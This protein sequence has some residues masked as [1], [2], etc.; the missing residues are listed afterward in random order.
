MVDAPGHAESQAE[1]LAE[2]VGV[3]A[4]EEEEEAEAEADGLAAVAP[5][6]RRGKARPR[7]P[8]RWS[9]PHREAL[10]DLLLLHACYVGEVE[11]AEL[12]ARLART[13]KN[14][15][16]ELIR[17]RRRL[18]P[19]IRGRWTAPSA[20]ALMAS[21]TSPKPARL[22]P[23]LASLDQQQQQ[24]VAESSQPAVRILSL[25]T[26]DEGYLGDEGPM[27][28]VSMRMSDTV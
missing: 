4:E 12:A 17:V 1:V 6:R 23:K 13:P 8:V 11:V 20:A 26:D 10:E 14:V 7:M 24:G 25:D 28:K 15:Q 18:C 9:R 21:R 27:F 3:A 5:A 16:A 22:A 2:I 19:F